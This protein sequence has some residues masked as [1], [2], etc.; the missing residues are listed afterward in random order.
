MSDPIPKIS[1]TVRTSEIPSLVLVEI[2]TVSDDGRQGSSPPRKELH[3]WKVLA[4]ALGLK[5]QTRYWA[6]QRLH[7]G[8]TVDLGTFAFNILHMP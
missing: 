8:A 4:S 7:A 6:E 2:I 3:N 1:I 5:S